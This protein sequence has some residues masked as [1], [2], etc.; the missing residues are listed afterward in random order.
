M[1]AASV[2]SFTCGRRDGEGDALFEPAGRAAGLAGV[3]GGHGSFA[4]HD[5][6]GDPDAI[7]GLT[8]LFLNG[9]APRHGPA[10]AARSPEA[11]GRRFVPVPD[12]AATAAA[13]TGV[14]RPSCIQ[15]GDVDGD[16]DADL[17]VGRS[18]D[19]A[20]AEK[21]AAR[22]RNEIWLG[23]GRGGFA[24][25]GD[26]GA[27]AET[28]TSACFVDFDR[29]S[30]LDLFVG[31]GYVAYGKGLE[32]YPDRLFRG[33]GDGTF[34]DVTERAGLL[35][36]AEPGGPRS[37][38]PTY[39][40]AH[41]D[42]NGDGR[43]DLLVMTYGRQANRLWRDEGDGTFTDVAPETGFDGDADRSGKYPEEVKRSMG[44]EDELPFRSHGNTFDAAAADKDGDGDI[45]C[46]LA[47]IAHAWAG[48]SSDRSTLLENLGPAEGYRFRRRPDLVPPR[49]H[50][51]D[52]WN[53]GDMHAGW[54]DVENDGRLD[55]VVASSEYP[56]D[57]VLKLY[58]QRSDGSFEDWTARLGFR[59]V[60]ASQISFGDFD[61]DGA[62]DLLVGTNETRLT[63][64][65]RARKDPTVGL[66]RNRAAAA[67][68]NG[69]LSLRL[70]G[71]GGRGAANRDAIGARVTVRTGDGRRQTREVL[72][73][74]G[75]AGHRDDTECRFG[76]GRAATARVDLLE[77]RWPDAAGTVQVFRDVPANR[78]YVLE[79]G[80]DLREAR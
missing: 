73:G 74:L 15:V 47:E 57:Q 16:G 20:E 49:R 1:A 56:D 41:T 62:T 8:R 22:A 40:V 64:E 3:R 6:D 11:G 4:D 43:Q 7:V 65:Q 58:H 50:E 27:A 32:S 79:Q 29:D 36:V 59:F 52:R 31:N 77:V 33:R 34:E 5:A 48:P 44:R 63:A 9:P 75:H 13:L 71:G 66:F 26:V 18:V 80:G 67:A 60:N 23:D 28:T 2:P 42:W 37:R 72:G 30:I 78:F 76:L 14:K 51:T 53:E 68:G 21:H 55:L 39:G 19:A 24:R 25:A 46:F 69:F 12:A 38:R 17:F 61:R 35:G 54:L 45:D 70:R 10:S